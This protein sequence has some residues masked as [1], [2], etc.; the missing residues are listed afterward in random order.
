MLSRMTFKAKLMLAFGLVG[1]FLLAVGGI[2]FFAL[3][4]TSGALTHIADVTLSKTLALGHMRQ[5]AQDIRVL[6]TRLGLSSVVTEDKAASYAAIAENQ[7]AYAAAFEAYRNLPVAEGEEETL[8]AVDAAWKR[9]DG[10]VQQL[11]TSSKSNDVLEMGHF[12]VLLSTDANRSA[13]AYFDA[14]GKLFEF[15][16]NEAKAFSRSAKLGSVL[17]SSV[18]IVLV[19]A[20]FLAALGLGLLIAQRLT[21]GIGRIISD[22]DTASTQTLS[23]SAQVSSSSHS[24]AEGANSQAASVEETSATLE[25]ISSMTRQNADNAGRAEKLAHQAQASTRQG[26]EAVVRM[27]TAIKSIKE[28]SDKT[29]RI[30]K[31]IDEIAFQTNLL[32]LNAAVE[33]ARAGEAGRGFAVVA[34]EVRNLAS[35]SATAA[36]D[37]SAL[38]EDSQRRADQ[39]VAVSGEVSQLLSD[40]LTT[41]GEMNTL[42]AEVA[43]AS[44]EQD[45]GV[46]Q[47]TAAVSQM[48]GIT[49]SNAASAEQTSAAAQELASQAQS[50]AVSVRRLSALMYGAAERRSGAGPVMALSSGNGG[51]EPL[52]IFHDMGTPRAAGMGRASQDESAQGSQGRA[53]QRGTGRAAQASQ[54]WKNLPAQPRPPA[55][56]GGLRSR[57]EQELKGK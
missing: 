20:G 55:E 8:A 42:V 7:K 33:A 51:G 2:N 52:R 30:V 16:E 39:G 24:L 23:A 48:D 25:E 45:R 50:L 36:K 14:A 17:W 12:M 15:Q 34:E 49:Q 31:T 47:I 53:V 27:T 56:S 9:Y 38:I 43:A 28:A 40:I 19:A 32:A 1:V 21:G 54:A 4:Q 11:V 3:R 35:R 22:L 6:T 5:T 57:L 44:K 18:S 13:A 41:A 46:Q 26:S 37:T 29:A 10:V